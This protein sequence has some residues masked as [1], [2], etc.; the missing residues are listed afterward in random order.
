MINHVRTNRK[1]LVLL[2]SGGLD[3]SPDP[4]AMQAGCTHAAN[5]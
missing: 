3:R 5:E 4:P 2:G 1:I